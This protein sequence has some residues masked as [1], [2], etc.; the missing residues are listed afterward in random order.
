MF[1]CLNDLKT[2]HDKKYNSIKPSA[3]SFLH[4]IFSLT[5]CFPK[6]SAEKARFDEDIDEE[7]LSS[8][9]EV[10]FIC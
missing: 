6:I 1:A 9:N 7:D 5:F 2:M 3:V 8:E 4:F 10:S